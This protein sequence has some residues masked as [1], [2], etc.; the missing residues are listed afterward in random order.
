M[1]H[2]A[3]RNEIT[4]GNLFRALL[5]VSLP[6][7]VANLLQ[8]VLEIV[9]L[10]FVGRLGTDAIAGVTLATSLIFFLVTVLIGIATATAA[11][12]S[13]AYG[14]RD[15]PEIGRVLF[16]ALVLGAGFSI[17]LMSVG[18]FFSRPILLLMG[19]EGAVADAGAAFLST[20]LLG[21]G[22]LVI[23]WLLIVS[24]QSTGDTRTPMYV[25]GAVILVNIAA[26]PV[27]IF[28]LY[29]FPSFGVAGSALATVLAR[30]MGL[31]ILAAI[32]LRRKRILSLP[33]QPAFD[34][35]LVRRLFGVA[36]PSA[37]QN[38]MRAFASLA[39]VAIVTAYGAAAVSAF[40]IAYRVEYILLMPGFAF[41]TGTA[42]LVGQNLGARHPERAE[43]GVRISL[44]IYG[45]L[46]AACSVTCILYA[47]AILG[48]FDPSGAS[49]PTGSSYF[50]TVAP[51][52]VLMAA[53]LVL[54]FAM[55]GA[56]ATRI[57]MLATFL[58]LVLVQI[59]LAVWLPG[60]TG[61]GVS[62]VWY[63][64]AIAITV[65]CGALVV[66]YRQGHWKS[67]RL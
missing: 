9:D 25:M 37:L 17:V 22:S 48:F 45:G 11:F 6:I 28:G 51:F 33:D 44:L 55:N 23:L 26:N 3:L 47:P 49:I 50:A 66:F 67:V 16:H 31:A 27:L 65:Q 2:E 36:A 46:M 13:R 62:G 54:A 34:P 18:A 29:G 40:G 53:S 14:A 60:W 39:L 4:E 43:E 57:P 32:V 1:T 41:A 59:P 35:T 30:T 64:I 12:I 42:V 5:S 7:L 20:F 21:I 38:G 63:A 19:A 24:F 8:G 58:S 15:Y 10:Y 56:G 61:T 52:Y